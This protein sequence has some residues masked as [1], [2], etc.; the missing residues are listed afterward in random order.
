MFCQNCSKA[1]ANVQINTPEGVIHYCQNCA[2]QKLQQDFHNNQQFQQQTANMQMNMN[3]NSPKIGV[4]VN[5]PIIAIIPM[6]E[7]EVMHSNIPDIS[8][9]KCKCS[10][11]EFL[12]QGRFSCTECYEAFAHQ[13]KQ[14]KV[15]SGEPTRYFGK[16]PVRAYRHLQ[17]LRQIQYLKQQLNE[18]VKRENYDNAVKLRDTIKNLEK[19]VE[20]ST[21]PTSVD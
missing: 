12:I 7:M 3:A 21:K 8:C 1:Q 19:E 5:P 9:K 16:Y 14:H 18:E 13:I 20:Q 4:G 6:I 10:F 17:L 2:L 15:H 11:N